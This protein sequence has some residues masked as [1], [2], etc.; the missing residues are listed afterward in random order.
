LYQD[1]QPER[2]IR[3][4]R[5]ALNILTGQILQTIQIR[6]YNQMI[7]WFQTFH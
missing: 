1:H 2:K 3:L 5:Y 7:H 6:R 4:G